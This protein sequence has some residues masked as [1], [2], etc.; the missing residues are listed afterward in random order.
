LISSG[1]LIVEA[2]EVLRKLGRAIV[3][4]TDVTELNWLEHVLVDQP[5]MVESAAEETVDSLRERVTDARRAAA[6]HANL[7]A[8]LDRIFKALG[9]AEVPS[10][11]ESPASDDES[12][13]PK[14]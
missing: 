3:E 9:G 10:P 1:L 8:V 13:E 14:A 4:R 5:N 7:A 11:N 2:D 6:E 12:T